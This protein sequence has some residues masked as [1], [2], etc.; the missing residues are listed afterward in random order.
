MKKTFRQ[1][2]KVWLVPGILNVRDRRY[3]KKVVEKT[4]LEKIKHDL[5]HTIILFIAIIALLWS[6]NLIHPNILTS[7][8]MVA[9]TAIPIITDIGYMI[10][11]IFEAWP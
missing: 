1:E 8:E 4:K 5:P 2:L 3:S 7:G 11:N 6:I 9:Y 10:Y